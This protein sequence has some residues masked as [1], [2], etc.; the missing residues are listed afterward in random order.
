MPF[1]APVSELLEGITAIC[2]ACQDAVT[3]TPME[4]QGTGYQ[5]Q[6]KGLKCDRCGYGIVLAVEWKPR[7]LYVAGR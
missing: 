6:V 2:P 5:E 1:P 4:H 3:A 7:W